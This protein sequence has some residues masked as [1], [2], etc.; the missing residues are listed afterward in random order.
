MTPAARRTLEELAS[1]E[2]CDLIRDGLHA[3]CGRRKV[4]TKTVSNLIRAVAIREVAPSCGGSAR[5]YE[6]TEMGRSY[7]RRP[8]LEWE[9]YDAILSRKGPFT[10]KDDRLVFDNS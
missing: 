10:V 9:Y 1:D 2:K 4:S 5:Y 6:I 8:D 7:L 3:Y